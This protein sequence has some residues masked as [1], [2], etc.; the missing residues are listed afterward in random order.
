MDGARC[1][2]Q[3]WALQGA[4]ATLGAEGKWGR[5]FFKSVE[6]LFGFEKPAPPFSRA[7][8]AR[9][10]CC[11]RG[12]IALAVLSNRLCVELQVAT[13]RCWNKARSAARSD[14]T[15]NV[16]DLAIAFLL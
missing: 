5:G 11:L 16:R 9:A 1:L 4:C 12:N 2:E 10:Q 13:N 15:Q 7:A 6:V 8:Q 14:D 3:R